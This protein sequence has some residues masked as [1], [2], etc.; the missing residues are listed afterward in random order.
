MA[1]TTV[2]LSI[3]ESHDSDS[4]LAWRNDPAAIAA[5]LDSSPVSQGDHDRWFARVIAD[6]L[7]TIYIARDSSSGERVGMCRFDCVADQSSAVI[8]INVAP[9]WR[10]RGVGGLVLSAALSRFHEDH[11]KA[12]TIVAHVRRDNAASTRL[13]LAAGFV[14][15][16]TVDD[17]QSLS[18]SL[19]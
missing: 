18:R 16:S 17:V 12:R 14:I 7:R 19:V 3:A 9:D 6:P 5:S 8:S 10:G 2:T 1:I 11:R 15:D 13:F 4:L